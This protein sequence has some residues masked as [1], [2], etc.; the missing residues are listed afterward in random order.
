MHS[1][2]QRTAASFVEAV[3]SRGPLCPK[4]SLFPA[5]T[6]RLHAGASNTRAGEDIVEPSKLIRG[7]LL[8][9]PEE[10]G[11]E[12][13]CQVLAVKKVATLS[14][15]KG[16]PTSCLAGYGSLLAGQDKSEFIFSK[17][18]SGC[19][20]CVWDMYRDNLHEYRV[21]Q[22]MLKG[23]APSVKALDPFEEMELKLNGL[24]K[25]GKGPKASQ[26]EPVTN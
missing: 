26:A 1:L 11:P 14:P 4:K 20:L 21:Q 17:L 10:P 12:D 25:E 3:C 6:T 2:L 22:A 18:Q 19:S 13:C 9:K 23:E 16:Q 15:C 24:A 5:Q 7:A 8:P